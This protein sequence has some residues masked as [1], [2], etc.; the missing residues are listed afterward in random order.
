MLMIAGATPKRR[1]G[2][3]WKSARGL[4]AGQSGDGVSRE[5]G[6][7][8]AAEIDCPEGSPAR[9]G[10]IATSKPPVSSIG[11]GTD[12]TGS[13]R[14]KATSALFAR[15]RQ[16]R[17]SNRGN[18]RRAECEGREMGRG[19][20]SIFI[21]AITLH[22]EKCRRNPLIT[23]EKVG[24]KACKADVRPKLGCSIPISSIS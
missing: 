21:V 7:R 2:L 16:E 13:P 8:S 11:A 19:S 22:E 14:S 9:G 15:G 4:R 12:H 10:A 18:R 6:N 1:N 20:L 3:A 24:Q 5:A 23:N 17:E